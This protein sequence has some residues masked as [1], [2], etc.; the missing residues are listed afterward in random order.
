MGNLHDNLQMRA[1]MRMEKKHNIKLNYIANVNKSSTI[2]IKHHAG[3]R[4][5]LS[6]YYE[7]ERKQ[8]IVDNLSLLMCCFFACLSLTCFL[9]TLYHRL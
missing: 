2:A 6:N 1:L 4:L 7:F 9:F 5:R 3:T 8:K